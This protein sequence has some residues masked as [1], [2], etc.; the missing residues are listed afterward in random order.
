ML[1][2]RRT[3]A[4]TWP[5]AYP[6]GYAVVD[7]ETTGLARDD[8]IVSAAVYRLDTH[9]NVEDHWYTLVNPERDPGP[10]WIHGLT[11]EALEGAPLFGEIAG[12][13][14]ARL[15]GRVLVAHNATFDWSMI[16]REYARARG[17]APTRQRLCTIA[18]AKELRLPLPNHKLESLAA[19]YGVVQQRAH[20]ALDDARVLAEAFRP[21]LHTA[22]RDGVRLPLLEC[23]PLT[24]WSDAPAAPRVGYQSSYGHSSWRPSRKR[25]PCPYPNPGRYEP[26]GQLV[27]GMRVA[28]SGDTSVE[29]ELLED[30][31]VE[32]GLHVATS[33]SRLTSLLVTNDPDA[34]TSKTVKAASYGTPVVDE[35]AFT[36]LLRDVAPA[37]DA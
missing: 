18:L 17:A 23:R 35:G 10:V 19:H 27:Q 29:R 7:V 8:R 11:S 15:D 22:A 1:D 21:S 16:A 20:H 6:Q 34:A 37:P 32:A 9:G 30:R 3:A 4:T 33:V 36:Q 13:L 26:G 31:A 14:S 24:E 25:P 5:A 12:E 2:D 28:F